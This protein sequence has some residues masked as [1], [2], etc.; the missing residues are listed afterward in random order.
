MERTKQDI[1]VAIVLKIRFL[2]VRF[3]PVYFILI[4]PRYFYCDFSSNTTVLIS[5]TSF[6]FY[7]KQLN[8]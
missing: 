5:L 4:Q 6:Y 7:I 3:L 2:V 1:K 8:C